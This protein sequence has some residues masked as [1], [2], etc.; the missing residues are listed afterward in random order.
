MILP[1]QAFHLEREMLEPLAAG[2]SMMLGIATGREVRIL[3]E[4]TL[5]TVI[6]DL[7]LGSWE[8]AAA[9]RPRVR[10]TR[11]DAHVI[12]FLEREEGVVPTALARRLRLS[13]VAASASIARLTRAKALL[14]D[15]TGALWLAPGSATDDIEIVAVE[16]KLAR[17]QDAVAQAA[18]YLEFADRSLVV[19]DGNRVRPHH[20]LVETARLA[21][22]GLVL[23]HGHL[24]RV[25][26]EA[27]LHSHRPTP[28]RVTAT[29]KLRSCKPNAAFWSGAA[30]GRES[31]GDD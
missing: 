30:A 18:T 13:A 25:V 10:T 14:V 31:R 5:G 23:Q 22:V 28:L 4:P 27:P 26:Q 29:S 21:G 20:R 24:L 8:P 12:A 11:I 2:L 6:P 9:P 19:L 1:A 15:E 3:R 7:L 17:W 16:A